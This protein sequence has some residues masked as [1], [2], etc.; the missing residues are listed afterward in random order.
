MARTL[1]RTAIAGNGNVIHYAHRS[2][3]LSHACGRAL[4]LQDAGVPFPRGDTALYV[5]LETVLPNFRF[6][7]F[8]S[9]GLFDFGIAC[10]CA[11]LLN[12]WNGARSGVARPSAAAGEQKKQNEL[13]HDH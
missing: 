5:N 12:P 11:I 13:T 10:S 9:D 3:A 7:Q 4:M 1:T 8:G 2:S 6:R